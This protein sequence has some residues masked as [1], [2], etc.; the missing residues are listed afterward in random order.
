MIK[1]LILAGAS[2]VGKTT[3][4]TL[5]VESGKFEL[6]RSATT[7]EKRDD[8]FG[9]EYIYLTRD[10]FLKLV[11]DGGVLEHTEYAG[12]LYGTPR[13]EIERISGEGKT[14][15][16]ILDLNGVKSLSAAEGIDPCSLYLY[17]HLN[18]MEKRL[19]DRYLGTSPTVDGLK[20]FQSRKEQNIADYLEM[21]KLAPCF[22]SFVKGRNSAE[23]TA[24]AV[25]EIYSAF[26]RGVPSRKDEN[27]QT[28]SEL[29]SLASERI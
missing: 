1:V 12:N 8:A 20:K 23:E 22:Y 7:R 2:A 29:V 27:L 19:Y 18:I 6:V 5:L 25:R 15:L 9:S 24:S 10:E 14:P 16:L 4:G 13:S 21:E 28:A 17:D 11:S 3:V 26:C